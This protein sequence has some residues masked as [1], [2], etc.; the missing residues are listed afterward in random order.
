MLIETRGYDKVTIRDIA[1]T[2]GVS[3]GLIYKYFPGGKFDIL[4]GFSYRYI[5]KL[6]MINQPETVD[7]N[8]FPGYVREVLK[9]M[10]KLYKEWNSLIKAMIMAALVGSE[11]V[12][13]VQKVDFKD[14]FKAQSEFFC[15]FNGVEIG[16]KDP[17]E[18]LM[19]WWITVK[20]IILCDMIYPFPLKNEEDL[21]DMMVNLSLKI[22]DYQKA[23]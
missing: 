5:D 17:Q 21:T 11:I 4:K 12:D 22:W 6:F 23:S 8:N 16:S 14:Y 19:H 13:E 1:E 9:N 18:V 7:F 15:R 2:A 10:Q 20:S 3:I